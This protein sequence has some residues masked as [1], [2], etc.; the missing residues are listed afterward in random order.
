MART[1]TRTDAREAVIGR[2]TRVRGK[3][4]G[5]G[6]LLVDGSIEGDVTIRGDLTVSSGATL[7]SNVDAN[8]VTV[9]GDVEGDIAARGMVRIEAGA[10]VRGDISG[11]S[12]ALEEG[13]EFAGRLD[14]QFDLPAEL[15]GSGHTGKRR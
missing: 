14:A 13:A 5:D 15:G 8:A 10:R 6:D 9:R 11:E 2:S 7:A 3:I 4:A 12:F 1:T